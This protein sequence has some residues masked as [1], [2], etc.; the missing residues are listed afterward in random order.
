MKYLL[1]QLGVDNQARSFEHATR[2][3]G[4]FGTPSVDIGKWFRGVLFPV[5]R[6]EE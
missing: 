1:D 4:D 6:F 3:D 2:P 5:L